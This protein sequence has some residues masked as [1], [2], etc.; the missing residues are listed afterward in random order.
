MSDDDPKDAETLRLRCVP[1]ET[2]RTTAGLADVLAARLGRLENPHELALTLKLVTDEDAWL[3]SMAFHL[4]PRE[5]VW[6]AYLCVRFA[7]RRANSKFETSEAM[8]AAENWLRERDD[9]L[10][11]RAYQCAANEG[12]DKPGALVGL[13]AFLSGA[14]VTPPNL[15][16]TPP[17][18]FAS[19]SAALSA[20]RIAQGDRPDRPL[21]RAE[22]A[23]RLGWEIAMGGSG[24]STWSNLIDQAEPSAAREAAA[25]EAHSAGELETDV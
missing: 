8:D 2:L 14:S 17:P 23:W 22:E 6:W 3:P 4:T 11:Y 1:T 18:P 9:S 24:K 21:V 7:A 19:C 10:R 12:F 25:K 5:G 20:V 15:H 16:P 13:A